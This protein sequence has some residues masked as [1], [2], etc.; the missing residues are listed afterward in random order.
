M[1]ASRDMMPANTDRDTKSGVRW[2]RVVPGFALLRT[3]S[4]ETQHVD[5]D[6]SFVRSLYITGVQYLLDGLPPDLTPTEVMNIQMKLPEKLRDSPVYHPDWPRLQ[7]PRTNC[8]HAPVDGPSAARPSLVHQIVA[9]GVIYFCRLVQFLLPH[10]RAFCLRVR[11]SESARIAVKKI[12]AASSFLAA[13]AR[14][15][16][17]F[18]GSKIAESFKT[19]SILGV[20]VEMWMGWCA[21][22]LSGISEGVSEGFLILSVGSG[23]ADEKRMASGIPRMSGFEA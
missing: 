15:G 7:N 13:K 9:A 14:V 8:R 4:G 21:A 16:V 2:N 5:A 17:V 12:F 6:A 1:S 18:L 11:E 20:L 3:A 22:V 19:S 23:K 10:V